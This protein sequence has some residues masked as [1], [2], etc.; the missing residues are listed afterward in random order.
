MDEDAGAAAGAGGGAAGPI[1]QAVTQ[2]L[3][4]IGGYMGYRYKAKIDKAN[5]QQALEGA[6]GPEMAVQMRARAAMGE[7]IAEQGAGGFQVG[8][9]S[10]FDA[11]EQSAT[12][13]EMDLMNIRRTAQVKS[14]AEMFQAKLDK[15]QA[16]T[17]LVGGLIGA[18][19][20][21]AKSFD[22]A[23]Y[24]NKQAY[25][26]TSGGYGGGGNYGLGDVS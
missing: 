24:Q 25:G 12:N 1:V 13:R 21:M 6:V 17:A 5:A 2:V 19:G 16:K 18:A 8:T 11:I 4:G 14:N 10:N 15:A 22:D 26:D 7:Q 23:A 20:V 9:G 3:G